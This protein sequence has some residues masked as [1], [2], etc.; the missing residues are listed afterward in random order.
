[1]LKELISNCGSRTL[2]EAHAAVFDRYFRYQM[3]ALNY[4]GEEPALQHQA[5]LE[6]A[7]AHDF[8]RAK[9]VL[10]D[11][12]TGCVEHAIAVGTIR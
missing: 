12:V 10:L 11:H 3:I 8:S 4:R 7:L 2:M 6:C 9:T 5:L 1:M